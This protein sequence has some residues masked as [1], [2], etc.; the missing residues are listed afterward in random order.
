[1]LRFG[2]Q[3]AVTTS[4]NT[5]KHIMAIVQ[6]WKHIHVKLIIG[7]PVINSYVSGTVNIVMFSKP[8]LKLLIKIKTISC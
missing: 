5:A 4:H 6:I 7:V 3:F 8:Q 2:F 1:M